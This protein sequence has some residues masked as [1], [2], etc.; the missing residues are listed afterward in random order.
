[1]GKYKK[2][3]VEVDA[4]QFNTLDDYL[5]IV[6]W[7]KASG[8]TFALAD[9]VRYST[10][11]MTIQTLEGVMA[12]SPGDWIIRGI[13]GEFY[14]CKPDIFSATY[15]PVETD[16][17]MQITRAMWELFEVLNKVKSNDRS[18]HDRRIAIAITKAE[19]LI[20]NY[21]YWSTLDEVKEGKVG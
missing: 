12:A 2:R 16:A 9:E 14:P 1:M 4:L 15:D 18:P 5:V 10:P 17:T 3:S 20:A 13:K 11:I 19:D 6:E 7:M 21:C 8:D